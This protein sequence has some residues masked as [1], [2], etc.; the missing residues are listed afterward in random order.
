MI[1]SSIAT[2]VEPMLVT[3]IDF[4]C[5]TLPILSVMALFCVLYL[6]VHA[7]EESETISRYWRKECSKNIAL[8]HSLESLITMVLKQ[9]KEVKNEVVADQCAAM[10]ESLRYGEAPAQMITRLPVTPHEINPPHEIN[11][12]PP[13][14]SARISDAN[15]V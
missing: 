9:A 15:P 3:M 13:E 10:L 11:L 8:R 1:V 4:V 7:Q 5:A 2:M 14:K 6:L 12:N